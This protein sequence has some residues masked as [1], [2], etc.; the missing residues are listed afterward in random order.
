M[1]VSDLPPDSVQWWTVVR[2]QLQFYLRTWRFV[3]LLLFILAVSF[4]TLGF[5]IAYHNSGASGVGNYLYGAVESVATFG[6][7]IGAFMGGDAIAMDFGTGTGYY[8]L[9]LPVRRIVLLLG[10]YTAAFLATFALAL[11]YYAMVLTGATWFYG[12][13]SIPWSDLVASLGI[14]ALFVLAVLAAAFLFSAFFRSPAISIVVTILILFL[15]FDIV[16]GVLSVTS[17]EPWFSLLYAGQ[18]SAL[19]FQGQPHLT[20]THLMAGG[21]SITIS[22]WTPYIWEGIAIMLGYIVVCLALSA[23][24]YEAK[25]SKG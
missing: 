16:D 21:R 12:I 17:I 23:V 20:V 18:A 1:D 4:A 19:V 13:S 14:T 25:E 22:A 11:V 9:V 24:I 7:I 8:V 10:R 15:A 6:V 5:Q 2:R 3:G